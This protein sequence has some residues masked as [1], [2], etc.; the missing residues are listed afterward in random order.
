VVAADGG[1][2]RTFDLSDRR[3]SAY[4]AFVAE[5]RGWDTLNYA[6]T[7]GDVLREAL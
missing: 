6:E 7:F 1:I 2:E 5:E 4:I 3:L